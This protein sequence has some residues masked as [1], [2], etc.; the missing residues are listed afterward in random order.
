[1]THGT[2]DASAPEEDTRTDLRRNLIHRLTSPRAIALAALVIALVAA[3][4]AITAW[5]RPAHSSQFSGQQSA[6]AKKAVCSAY[7]T[8]RRGVTEKVT[9]LRPDDPIAK[10]ALNIRRNLVLLAS[11]VHLH[12]TLAAQPA[13]PADLAKA[14]D[15]LANTLEHVSIDH[16]AAVDK[17]SQAQLGH[18]FGTE[19]AQVGKLCG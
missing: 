13:T 5:L 14:V 4:V 18:D 7:F 2:V 1:M 8:V 15:S 19:L 9:N 11:S 10:T 3:G 12:D 6:D 16:L 17:K